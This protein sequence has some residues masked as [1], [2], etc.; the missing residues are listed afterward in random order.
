MLLD[1]SFLAEDLLTAFLFHVGCGQGVQVAHVGNVG[2]L[3]DVV[4]C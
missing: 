4:Q 3:G 2:V 1:G